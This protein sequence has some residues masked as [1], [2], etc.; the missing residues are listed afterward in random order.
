[1]SYSYG[2][3]KPYVPVAQRRA[4]AERAIKKHANAGAALQ[5]VRIKGRTIAS[6][7][8]GKGWCSHL[9]SFSDFEN[10]LPRGRTY[11]R[12]GSVYH[13]EIAAGRVDARV[14][15]SSM[16]TV[17]ANIKPLKPA[18]WMLLK[19]RC[20]GG[21]GSLL[22]LLQGRLSEQVMRVVTDH[23]HGLFPQPGEMT[24]SCTCPDWASMCKHVAATLYGVG[25][26]LDQHP[27]LLFQLRGIDPTEL[28]EAAI[29]TPRT[30]AAPST[31][32]LAEDQLGALFGI[33][34][35][36]TAD[37]PP[38]ATTPRPKAKPTAPK[39]RSR[40]TEFRATGKAVATLR[41]KLG[42][43]IPDFAARLGVSSASV[44]RWESAGIAPLNLQ[45]R[46]NTALTKLHRKSG[47]PKGKR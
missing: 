21:I 24:F 1:M 5:P 15:G 32:S 38:R 28:I 9:E 25:N 46:C 10:R 44:Q 6:S 12:N 43:S 30:R 13:L 7:F 34:L 40:R 11:V 3:W 35:E 33:E 8:W 17:T 27:E 36:P 19:Q 20:A 18:A 42:L 31:D 45:T 47:V 26:R 2:S 41:K 23:E 22:E 29:H 39:A 37:T 4:K 14:I 16:Y